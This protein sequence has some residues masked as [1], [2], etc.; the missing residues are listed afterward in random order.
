[1][2]LKQFCK[3][4]CHERQTTDFIF[5]HQI[6]IILIERKKQNIDKENKN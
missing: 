5:F 6:P 3:Y 2:G 1:M 4:D